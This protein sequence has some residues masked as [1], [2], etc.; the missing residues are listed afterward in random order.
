MIH[1]VMNHEFMKAL[2]PL[3]YDLAQVPDNHYLCPAPKML[4]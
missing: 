3:T 4:V 1:D 2:A